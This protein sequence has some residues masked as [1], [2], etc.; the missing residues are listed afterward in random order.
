MPLSVAEV[1][2]TL[3]AEPFDAVWLAEAEEDDL[4]EEDDELELVV[5]DALKL[6]VT[7]LF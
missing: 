6:I 4:E 2:F 5:P 7:F 1:D 3:V